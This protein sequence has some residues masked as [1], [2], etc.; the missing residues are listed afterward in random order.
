[1]NTSRGLTVNDS[2]MC[3]TCQSFCAEIIV[4]CHL[5]MR[6]DRRC[7]RHIYISF[8]LRQMNSVIKNNASCVV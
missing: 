3:I 6:N 7:L 8:V 1:M 5:E 4:E 2:L